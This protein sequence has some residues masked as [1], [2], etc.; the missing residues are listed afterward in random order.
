MEELEAAV[1]A[2][3]VE[4]KR[5]RELCGQ[6]SGSLLDKRS[7]KHKAFVEWNITMRIARPNN[8]NEAETEER[9]GQG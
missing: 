4:D 6:Y 8:K 9:D 3:E 5:M 7:S 2:A 1:M